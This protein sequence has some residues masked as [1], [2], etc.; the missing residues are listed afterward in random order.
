[1]LGARVIYWVLICLSVITDEN[2]DLSPYLLATWIY[3][4]V[5]FLFMSPHV[6]FSRWL[7]NSLYILEWKTLSVLS[8][9]D[10]SGLLLYSLL[11]LSECILFFYHCNSFWCINL[12]VLVESFSS[13]SCVRS[14]SL[15]WIHWDNLLCHSLDR[16]FLSSLYLSLQSIW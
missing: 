10:L 1:M 16:L 11:M 6:S 12:F 4:F 13:L 9:A 3:S 14:L 2:E 7:R 15:S 8:A 5:K